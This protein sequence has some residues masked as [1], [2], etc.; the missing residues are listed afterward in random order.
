MEHASSSMAASAAGAVPT[1]Q[2]AE[3]PSAR[4]AHGLDERWDAP[5]LGPELEAARRVLDE[6]TAASLELRFRVDDRR[7]V[8]V[9]V[10]GSDGQLI[11]EIPPTR[12]LDAIAGGGLV[13]DGRA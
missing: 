9:Q 2:P 10:L 1:P 13:L 4:G 6:L 7:R 8:H 11:R 3:Q 12:L 5:D